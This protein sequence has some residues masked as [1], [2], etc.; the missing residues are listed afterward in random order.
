MFQA[1]ALDQWLWRWNESASSQSLWQI[2]CINRFSD[3]IVSKGCSED[4]GQSNT[5]RQ[6][7]NT[8]F[9]TRHCAFKCPP[10]H[11][12]HRQLRRFK[13]DAVELAYQSPGVER[14]DQILDDTRAPVVEYFARAESFHV[15]EVLGR[16]SSNDLVTCCFRELD[17]ITANARRRPA[18][19]C[20]WASSPAQWAV[21]SQG[22]ELL[23]QAASSSRQTK[24]DDDC[25]LER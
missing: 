22:K 4:L 12:F 20:L 19:S 24:W 10:L 21:A 11:N 1:F 2:S 3:A 15:L 9:R 23:E 25:F 5:L 14:V 8:S 18:Q 16:R 17:T 7:I 13:A 6:L